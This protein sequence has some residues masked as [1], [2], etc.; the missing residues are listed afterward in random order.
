MLSM[1]W[2]EL[3]PAAIASMWAVVVL[4]VFS[5]LMYFRKFWHKI[6]VKVKRRR[7]RELLIQQARE[8]RAAR[9]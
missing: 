5:A 8:R 7:R 4:T 6:D 3:R 9:G 2:T 1:Q